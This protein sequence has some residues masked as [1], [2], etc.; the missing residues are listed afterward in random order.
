MVPQELLDYIKKELGK[1]FSFVQIQAMLLQYNY[2]QELISEAFSVLQAGQIQQGQ[3]QQGQLQQNQQPQQLQQSA[4]S[5]DQL[6][7]QI[8]QQ[9]GQQVQQQGQAQ[10]QV[11]QSVNASVD[12]LKKSAVHYVYLLS[13]LITVIVLF[14]LI[15]RFNL[16]PNL[17][18][19]LVYLFIAGMTVV[20]AKQKD[21]K[22][23]FA[24]QYK[25]FLVL[26]ILL[27]IFL[28]IGLFLSK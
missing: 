9:S 11:Q 3:V 15:T 1:G 22:P 21:V 12:K 7:R 20:L 4:Q 24:L 2:S 5:Q 16:Y 10:G 6:G 26:N 8:E 27:F 18:K 28:L 19:S 13:G 14:Q 23:K 17:V 25:I